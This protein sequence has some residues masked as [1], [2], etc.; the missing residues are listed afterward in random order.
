MK[1]LGKLHYF[2]GIE[3]IRTWRSTTQFM[4]YFGSV[5]ITWSSEKQPII[6]FLS[7]EA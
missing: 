5:A 3:L 2:I 4:F 1:D 7:I 6:S